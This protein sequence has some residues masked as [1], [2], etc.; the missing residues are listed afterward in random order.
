VL[1]LAQLNNVN[2]TI[3]SVTKRGNTAY[4]TVCPNIVPNG[5]SPQQQGSFFTVVPAAA[6]QGNIAYIN[7][8]L[9]TVN[10]GCV[11]VGVNY[12]AFPAQSAVFLAVN[13]QILASSYLSIGY[14]ASASSFVSASININLPATPANVVPPS[15]AINVPS[16]SQASIPQQVNA[17]FQS[18]NANSLN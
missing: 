12:N 2:L 14:T 1:A 6:D 9:S 16:D 5:L 17:A 15:N 11:T 3:S 13:A 4:I 10:P 7:Q 8:W 18:A